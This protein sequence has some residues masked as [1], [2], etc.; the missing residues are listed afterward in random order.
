MTIFS[1]AITFMVEMS[2]TSEI[3]RHAT[4]KSL[5]ILMKLVEGHQLMMA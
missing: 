4:E 2:E 3:L 1:E 5:I